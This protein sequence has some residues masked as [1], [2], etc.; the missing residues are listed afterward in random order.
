[1]LG[2]HIA[3]NAAADAVVY[4]QEAARESHSFLTSEHDHGQHALQLRR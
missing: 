3:V 4:F 1:V 2:P